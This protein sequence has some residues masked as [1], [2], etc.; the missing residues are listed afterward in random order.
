MAMGGTI[1][2]LAWLM[3]LLSGLTSGLVDDGVS[4]LRSLPATHIAFAADA[5]ESFSKS[6]LPPTAW[7]QAAKIPGIDDATPLGNAFL[8]ARSAVGIGFDLAL[9]GVEPGS[10]LDPTRTAAITY[11][12]PWIIDIVDVSAE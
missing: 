9:F 10:F 5:D 11:R 12:N 3:T 4:S 2:L 7:E 8:N 6:T 1:A